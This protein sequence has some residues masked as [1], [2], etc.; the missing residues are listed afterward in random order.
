MADSKHTKVSFLGL[1]ITIGIVYGDIGTSPLYVMNALIDGTRNS[2]D[3]IIGAIS[4]VIWTLTF[5]TTIKYVLITLRAHNNGEGGIFSLYALLRK[6]KK[7]VYVFAI[8]GGATFLA[9]GVLTPS[10]TITSAIEGLRM[11]NPDIPVIQIVLVIF[12]FL[13]TAQQFG[14]DKLGKSFGPI[15]F[16]WFSV[17]G[18]LGFVE[19][20]KYPGILKA[21]NP[22]YVYV[23]LSEF[24]EGFVL[25]GAV[26]LCTTGAEALYSDLGHC[27]YK[28]IQISWIFVKTT[29]I[30]NYLGQGAWVLNNPGLTTDVVNPFFSIMPSWFLLPGIILAT[31]ASVIASQALLSGTFTLISE[32]IILNFWPKIKIDHPT[33][34]K[35]QMYIP[36]INWLLFFSCIIVELVFKESAK[37]EAAYGLAITITMLMT[38]ILVTYHLRLNK[39]RNIPT[40]A[41][42]MAVFLIIEISFLLANVNKFIHGG[43]FTI[44]LSFIFGLV[45]YV[46]FRAR[47]IKKRFL[48]FVKFANYEPIIVDLE[49]DEMVPRFCSNLVYLTKADRITDVESKIMYSILNKYPKRADKYW[50]LHVN[51]TDE[52]LTKEYFVTKL[53]PGIAYRIDFNIGFRV[54]P[55]INVFFRKVVDD[56]IHS[57]EVDI[58][59]NFPS[60]RKHKVQGDFKFVLI[61][62]IHTQDLELKFM[63]RLIMNLFDFINR[64]SITESKSFG[65]DTSVVIVEKV[66][67]HNRTSLKVNLTRISNK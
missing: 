49:K 6:K 47:E 66:P 48:Q 34:I 51:Y 53:I 29:L 19:I 33:E 62:R 12:V 46:W 60:L 28:N 36:F 40:I 9:N 13:F 16:I 22:W 7:F 20:L 44:L 32:A 50:F 37:M 21:F 14:T 4:C 64:I 45:M 8:V 26:F 65:L 1:I 30:I 42:F 5:Q 15:M 35:G 2:P 10:I 52:P 23:F 17:L 27:G 54:N 55:K 43:W 39:N 56:L 24:P 25:L 41:L 31:L 18:I 61:D 57:K 59:S 58:V 63:D 67:L 38:T 11:I 3:F